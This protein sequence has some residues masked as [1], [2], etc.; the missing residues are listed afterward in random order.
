MPK[1]KKHAGGRPR[2][3][4]ETL[5]RHRAN[6]LLDDA[7]K[8]IFDKIVEE[9]GIRLRRDVHGSEI[10]RALVRPMILLK[11]WEYDIELLPMRD[12]DLGQSDIQP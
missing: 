6:L 11:S 3:P 10:V 2:E 7:E 1:R 8:K 12:N 5:R 4:E 9:V